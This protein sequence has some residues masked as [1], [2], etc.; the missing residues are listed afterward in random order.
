MPSLSVTE[1]R[2]LLPH[3]YPMLMIDRV[4]DYSDDRLVAIKAVTSN[5]PVFQGHFPHWP[6]FPGVLILEAMVQ[7]SAVMASLALGAKADDNRVYLFAGIDKARFKQ[8]V[9]PGD[10][11][12]IKTRSVRRIRDIWKTAAEAKVDD[13]V[14]CSAELLFT[15]QEL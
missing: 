9:V 7:A 2:E 12:Q 3:R 4:L 10:C 15:F 8:P 13:V 5:E 6:I 14:V 11:I 1:I